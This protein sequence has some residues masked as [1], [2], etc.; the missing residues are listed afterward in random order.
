MTGRHTVTEPPIQEHAAMHMKQ[1]FSIY[2]GGGG[3]GEEGAI[4]SP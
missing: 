4:P 1:Q 2:M 3:R